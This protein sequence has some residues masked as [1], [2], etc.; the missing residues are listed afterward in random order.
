MSTSTSPTPSSTPRR[1]LSLNIDR[2][3]TSR[4]RH[5]RGRGGGPVPFQSESQRL[6]VGETPRHCRSVGS[7]QVLCYR[8]PRT[9]VQ[10]SRSPGRYWRISTPASPQEQEVATVMAASYQQLRNVSQPYVG[11]AYT[12]PP[13]TVRERTLALLAAIVAGGTG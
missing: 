13:Q 9:V 10:Y 5:P 11:A 8:P 1:S 7:R 2:A 4:D 6:P 3:A 12:I